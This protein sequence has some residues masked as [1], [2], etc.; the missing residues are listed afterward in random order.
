MPLKDLNK[1]YEDD[2]VV[3]TTPQPEFVAQ[4][5]S[6]KNTPPRQETPKNHK[7]TTV[8]EIN[9]FVSRPQFDIINST[10]SFGLCMGG[11]GSGKTHLIAL[12]AANFVQNFP[13]IV[14]FMGANTY[15][16]LGDSTLKRV[17]S[18]WKDLFGWTEYDPKT[19]PSGEYVEGR[20]P[21]SH[22]KTDHHNIS[23]KRYR[24]KLCFRNG[25][26]IVLGSMDAYKNLDGQEFAYA[27]LD[28]TKDT[29]EDA[30]KDVILGRLRMG[31]IYVGR[32]RM[33][34]YIIPY[35]TPEPFDENGNPNPTCNPLRIFTSPAKVKWLNEMFDMT[36]L[37]PKI[38][39]ECIS[40]TDYFYGK[41]GKNKVVVVYSVY[42]NADNLP[43]EYI[44]ER[45]DIH[46]HDE[47]RRDMLIFGYPFGSTGNEFWKSFKR[48]IHVSPKVKMVYNKNTHIS[49]DQNIAPYMTCILSQNHLIETTEEYAHY[50]LYVPGEVCT[51]NSTVGENVDEFIKV[52][53]KGKNFT[54]DILYY[55]DASMHKKSTLGNRYKDGSLETGYTVV[56]D[57][58]MRWLSRPISKSDRTSRANPSVSIS[59][60]FINILMGGGVVGLKK[61]KTGRVVK[62][63]LKVTFMFNPDAK[64]LIDDFIFCKSDGM[65]NML[66]PKNKEGVEERGHAS[67]AFRYL[68][69]RMFWQY[70]LQY[71]Q[72]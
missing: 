10:E 22:F 5:I 54:G 6:N 66:K 18:V 12:V 34:K 64:E 16:Q 51:A 69:I 29:R 60:N 48:E 35:F 11:Q 56:K 46:K 50:L 57:K 25:H 13:L 38:K 65:G 1:G 27:L 20:K 68:V 47:G 8:N 59:R 62:R 37:Q 67:D 63:G 2:A 19:N 23:N 61:D 9:V 26:M 30:I 43:D 55:G 4:V 70:Y 7:A 17:R 32:K 28:E 42:H 71:A 72:K 40:K 14:G 33:G 41:I 58:L 45:E 15:G 44:S 31:G 3:D 39:Q 52:W 21:P 24:N 36:P 49:F 53:L